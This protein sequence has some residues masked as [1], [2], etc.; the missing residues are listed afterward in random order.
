MRKS[1][2][3]YASRLSGWIAMLVLVCMTTGS[4]KAAD[5]VNL[6]QVELNKVITV[7]G[8]MVP[9]YGSVVPDKDGVMDIVNLN[10][11]TDGIVLFSDAAMT[12]E[13]EGT[14]GGYGVSPSYYYYDV[15][16]GTTY[17]FKSDWGA[18]G[19]AEFM[20]R[21]A[22][23][24]AFELDR[25]SPEQGSTLSL[26]NAYP[27]VDVYFST[28]LKSI[29][30]CKLSCAGTVV[31][32]PA[33]VSNS[34]IHISYEAALQTLLNANVA[35]GTEINIDI[36]GLTNL[37]GDLYNGNGE[38]SLSFKLPAPAVTLVSSNVPEVFKSYWAPGDKDAICTFTFSAPLYTDMPAS[39]VEISFGSAEAEGRDFYAENIPFTIN[40]NVITADLSGVRRT[41]ADM[42]ESG[43]NY[44]NMLLRLSGVKD[45]DGNYVY[46]AGKGTTGSFMFDY[47]GSK[48]VVIPK[49]SIAAE[50]TPENGTSLKDATQIS[51][52][53]QGGSCISFDGFTLTAEENGQV[54]TANVPMSEVTV[55]DQG[56]DAK[57]YTFTIPAAIKGKSGVTVTLTNVQGLDGYD[58]TN[59]ITASYDKFVI[60]S[61]DPANGAQMESFAEGTQLVVTTNYADLYPQLYME[62]E[63]I[64]LNAEDPDE[65]IVKTAYWLT[66]Q[67][68]GSFSATSPSDIKL[69]RGHKY[70]VRFTAW[71]NEM[72]KNY[73][74]PA[75]G[76]YSIYWEGLTAPFSYSELSFVSI[77]P[78]P[79]DV[80]LTKDD[81]EFIITFDGSV[82][83]DPETTF[84]PIGS[85]LSTPFESIEPYQGSH[86]SEGKIYNDSWKLTV[87]ESYMSNLDVPLAISIKA[88]DEDGKIVRGNTGT[89]E[90]TYFYFT[91]NVA[92]EYRAVT[93]TPEAGTELDEISKF[94]VSYATGINQSYTPG[95]EAYLLGKDR[96]RYDFII[97]MGEGD[98]TT[99]NNVIYLTLE[100][101]ITTPGTYTLHIDQGFFNLGTEYSS[102]KSL[103]VDYEYYVKEPQTS[104]EDD[105]RTY[106]PSPEDNTLTSLSQVEIT[107]VDY[108][109][110][111]G[112]AGKATL[113]IN[114]AKETITLPDA[115]YGIEWNAMV[116]PLGN[117]YT[118]NGTY[119]IDFPAGYFAL[120]SNGDES[121]AF[122]IV[123]TLS[124]GNVGITN[125]AA[126]ANGLY[127]VYNMNG[128]K[129]LSTDKAADFAGL[130]KGIYVIN[131]QKVYI[132]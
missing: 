21:M 94:E 30:S 37:S 81:R 118:A 68:D 10:G 36:T 52:W 34:S 114:G 60:T 54:T 87:S 129:V 12:N 67:E 130:E 53:M 110:V 92:G 86:E 108:N 18:Y 102:W 73:N 128:V 131:G 31:T 20:F 1:L 112:A 55:D 117:T 91:Y 111:A 125:I 15:K 42:L 132:K 72:L 63:I 3:A 122:A 35:A 13:I 79:K 106:V 70:E 26:T 96:T 48:Y 44:N 33:Q 59:D 25:V 47:S 113:T 84:I 43:T 22:A 45:A 80:L 58:H 23:D 9:F 93:V 61:A 11:N 17:Y 57:E 123:Y 16:G 77:T 90:Q 7:E 95:A 49:G 46:S 39:T 100:Q 74:N 32:L 65:A 88:Y 29:T 8:N 19:G 105:N 64:D 119:T 126:D 82:N 78:D 104:D 75:I 4:M 27:F 115:E 38:L 109:E 103:G 89:E 127:N 14:H 97:S 5:P 66:R 62:Y 40:G 85:G 76:T 107:F 71:E 2:T 6:G 28:Q 50:F 120:G 98:E 24:T 83:L 124:N 121:K 101:P 56:N 99:T 69:V 51:V 41:P 116:Q